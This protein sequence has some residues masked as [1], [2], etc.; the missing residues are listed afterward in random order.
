MNSLSCCCCCCC[1]RIRKKSHFLKVRLLI[2]SFICDV[3]PWAFHH[4][5]GVAITTKTERPDLRFWAADVWF[6]RY[7]IATATQL[8][9]HK[10]CPSYWRTW[11]S[12]GVKPLVD[13][14]F[15]FLAGFR[16]RFCDVN[17]TNRRYWDFSEALSKTNCHE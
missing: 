9:R 3:S 16:G 13:F 5:L 6:W 12:L 11:V 15:Y 17:T 10:C 1:W 14:Y 7:S 2:N 8:H 4:W